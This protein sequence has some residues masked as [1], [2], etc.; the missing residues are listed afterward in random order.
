FVLTRKQNYLPPFAPRT[1]AP[2]FL[3]AGGRQVTFDTLVLNRGKSWYQRWLEKTLGRR[4]LL[5]SAFEKAFYLPVLR[6]LVEHRVLLEETVKGEP[7]WG[8][9]PEVLFLTDEVAS[10]ETR[11]RR[12]VLSVPESLLPAVTGM[13]SL[14]MND[15]GAYTAADAKP[16][17]LS[18]LYKKGI[19]NRVIAQEHTGL[20]ER[21]TREALER[22]FLQGTEPWSPNLLSATPT[23]EM[24]I[25]IGDLS[26]VLLCSVPP[27]QANYVQRVGR[28]GRRD[29]NAFNLTLATGV[30]HDLY[31]YADPVEM[32]AGRVEPPGVFLN[33]SAVI[34]RQLTAFCFDRWVADGID[35]ST[36]P[37]SLRS[38]L[39]HVEKGELRRFPYNL[40]SFTKENATELIEAFYQ[41][42][43]GELS[44][45]TR[46]ALSDFLLG[47]AAGEHT[48]EMHLVSRLHEMVKE[49]Q[50]LKSRIDALKRHID[51]LDKQPLDEAVKKERDSVLRERS[52]LQSVLHS[53][54][55]KPTLNFFTDEGLLPNYAFPEAGVTLRSVIYRRRAEPL[56]GESA[57]ENFV[58]EYERPGMAAISELAPDNRFYAGGR[59]V[60]IEQ[61]DLRLSEVEEW[62]FCPSC[63]HAE[64]LAKGD[65][66]ANCP[67]CGDIMWS[68]A[69]QK[70]QMVR[71]KQVM[72]NTSDKDSRIGD[73]SDDREPT[74]YTRQMLA[75]FSSDEI[76]AAF[77]IASDAL[78]FGFE[79]LRKVTFREMNFGE[80]GGEDNQFFIASVEAA[81]LGF[82]MCRH[83][84]M[85]QDRR[86]KEQKH[87][88]TCKAKDHS[89]DVNL[90]D[91]LYLY[92]EFS[93]EAIRI[94]M[95]VSAL[96]GSEKYLNS[97]IAAIQLGLKLKFGGQVDHLRMMDYV[98][99][100]QQGGGQRHFLM[101][102][103]SVPG[104]T[105][106]LHD[107]MRSAEHLL[108]VFRLA[109]DAMVGCTC[110]QDPEKD[111]CYRCIYAYRNS[112]GMENTSRNL[113]V[114]MLSDI[115]DARE[116]FEPVDTI[117]NIKINPLFDSELEARFIEAIKRFSLKGLDVQIQPQV[118]GGKPGYF[119]RIGDRLYTVEPQS[120]VGQSDGVAV[121]SCPDFM[122]RSARLSQVFK[123]IAVFLDGYEFHKKTV[124][125]D[126]VKRLALVQSGEFL[127]WSLTW[128]DV[129]M[130]FGG[131]KDVLRNPF[132]EGLH[133]EMHALQLRL[134]DKLGV[135]GLAHVVVQSC[136]DQLMAYLQAPDDAAWMNLAFTRCLG[137]FEQSIM[138][139]EET[140]D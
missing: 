80:Y 5:P 53:I 23:L 14:A 97:L 134:S 11:D 77:R 59:K 138:L 49:R 128:Q 117:S 41:L 52:G 136:F 131:V 48:F 15:A 20:L 64:N 126:S 135:S 90:L 37:N 140:R 132:A 81:R 46:Q 35:E 99:P 47:G 43:S 76:G 105:G 10:L 71:L 85:V 16:H 39:D 122:I 24:G 91:C 6:A 44:E 137:W 67:R 30:P 83:C 113:A 98:E 127:Q 72:A 33:A 7:V 116:L 139:D 62:R 61:V 109:R 125:E 100:S 4:R 9:N 63:A 51:K 86:K 92:R 82:R 36:I 12:S 101:L 114:S 111:G 130:Q 107:L 13:P 54:N 34:K 94:L 56:E 42:F 106:Y 79:Y 55:A 18:N 73:D 68:D 19:I 8:L 88:F 1:P 74:F 50:S 118:V 129:Q 2:V 112:Y 21:D 57:F 17:W 3:A 31:F 110:N 26:S 40:I 38:V 104:G 66:A 96:S 119:L 29:G 115:L 69:G 133:P 22:A 102:Y 120:K 93:S 87:A 28:A 70:K 58:F 123:P 95:P 108:E 25:D 60:R 84:G 78:P 27:T 121:A 103:D 45:R 75:D 89:D 124:T 65:G 32:M